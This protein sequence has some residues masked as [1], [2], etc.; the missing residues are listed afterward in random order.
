MLRLLLTSLI[1]AS[2]LFG[3]DRPN[4]LW[5]TYEDSSPHLGCYG[6]K[7]ATTPNM[8][9]LAAKG[10]KYRMAWSCA[11]VC[12]PARTCIISG[13]WA[14]ADGAEHMRSEVPMPEGHQMYPQLLRSAG[15]YCTNNSKEDYNLTKPDG[16]W[17]ESSPNAHWRN[18]KPG[19]PFFAV[20][21]DTTS[22]E[23]Q[24]RA[25]PHT[26]IHDPAKVDLPIYQPDLPEVRHD[27]AQ[28]FDN[29]TSVDTTI[30]EALA[31]LKEAGL[32]QDTIVMSYADHG[33]GMP[34]SKR[35]T[36]N[37]GLQVPFIAYFPEKWKHLAP[38]DYTV[39]GTSERIISFIDLAPT[40]LSIIGVKPPE[41]FQGRAFAGEFTAEAP[42]YAFGFRGRM[43]ERYDM[44]RSV[45]DGRFVYVRHFYP[46]LPAAQHNNYMF[47]Q[48]TT[49]VWYQEFAAG[50][51]NPVQSYVWQ[52]KASEELYDLQSDRWE[53]S[54]VAEVA[55]NKAKLDELRTALRSWLIETR[56]LGFIPEAQRLKEAAG[57]S[58]RDY[59]SSEERYPVA[60]VV[61]AALRAT[62]RSV[63]SVADLLPSAVAAV[64]FWGAQGAVLRKTAVGL[65]SL[66]T[67]GSTSVQTA[68]AEALGLYGAES[69]KAAAWKVLLFNAD[70]T[71]Q[72]TILATEALNV[73]DHLGLEA[74][75][76]H[77]AE[78]AAL[79][80][81]GA[82]ADPARTRE[83][84]QRV[85]EYLGPLLGYEVPAE[86]KP[87]KRKG[88]KK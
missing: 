5:L 67:D 62:D 7:N 54:N 82:G 24:I 49:Q 13:R 68:A 31:E 35:W 61:D 74:C 19:Q 52:P 10:I 3:A 23:S 88:K 83:Y 16:V 21:N 2:A 64:R 75:K 20:F 46:H 11:P 71:K 80:R 32:E 45:T 9:A 27:W 59:Y 38:K 73:I 60:T 65:D 76:A 22:H 56:D 4:I 85:H 77:A 47:Q 69:Q 44:M 6:D 30:G 79:P 81:L 87:A 34:R 57:K 1:A 18:R 17:D 48:A 15:Y 14:P 63:D 40:L 8:D 84:S 28:H 36:Y 55:G 72:S 53:V 29:L 37:S 50:R 41:Y 42:K 58:P 66:L 78:I 12:A 51:L 33:T 26:L 43:D 70:P 86:S 25:R 39:G